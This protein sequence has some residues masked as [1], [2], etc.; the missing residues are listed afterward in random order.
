MRAADLLR[1]LGRVTLAD[2]D[3]V[4][5]LEQVARAHVLVVRLRHRIDGQV[6]DAGAHLRVVVSATTGLDHI[7]LEE[8][9]ERGVA[10]LSLR[11]ETEFLET[12][13]ATAEHTWG[14]LLALARNL[15]SAAAA[16]VSGDWERDR[17]RG[18]ELQGKRL[19]IL[20]FGRLGRMVARY[21]RAF[22][23]HVAAYDPHAS[24]WPD[25]VERQG[26]MNALIERSD[27]LS[28]HLPLE[29]STRGI[30]DAD[31][32]SRLPAG[33]ILIN[34]ARGGLVD[35]QALVAALETG[36]LSGAACD[37]VQG[38]SREG[39]PAS[40]LLVHYA[41]RRDNL[42]LTPHIGG[43]TVESM[44]RTEMFMAEKLV[45]FVRG[46]ASDLA[47]GT[48]GAGPATSRTAG[49]ASDS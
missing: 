16:A 2:L 24:E 21:G 6:L 10:V 32:L 41:R 13:T 42:I 12:V 7:D 38:E 3:R 29:R 22:A 43:A 45:R 8:A 31:S 15:P 23:M 19:G 48:A 11:G 17:F 47:W 33:A 26:S 25:F 28:L 37:V 4:G 5:L 27:V 9:A 36:R 49:R 39:G 20:G 34:T 35:E 30:I 46:D 40:S 44:E 14:L 18:R 1:T